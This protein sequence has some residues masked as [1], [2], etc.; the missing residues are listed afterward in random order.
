MTL[1]T[2]RAVMLALMRTQAHHAAFLGLL[3]SEL[4]DYERA[5]DA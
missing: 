4:D 1:R 5:K 2:L 3:L